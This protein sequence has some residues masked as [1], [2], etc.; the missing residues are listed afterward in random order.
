MGPLLAG[1]LVR[2]L[3]LNDR[4]VVAK[5]LPLPP[6]THPPTFEPQLFG[7]APRV[8]YCSAVMVLPSSYPSSLW[9]GRGNT[10]E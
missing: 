9:Y 4:G 10:G 6:H 8:S 2:V 1:G 7:C 5:M 3:E